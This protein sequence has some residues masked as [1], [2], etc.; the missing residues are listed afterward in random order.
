[1]LTLAT[2]VYRAGFS[3]ELG[4]LEYTGPLSGMV[5]EGVPVTDFAKPRLRAALRPLAS[6]LRQS[7]PRV[8]L[9]TFG[10]VNLALLALRPL[11]PADIRLVIREANTPSLSLAQ[12][13]APLLMGFAYR[14]LYPTA[15]L[16]LCQHGLMAAEM[17][18]RFGVSAERIAIL[19]N[20]V[21]V[22][23]LRQHP[24][25]RAPGSGRRFVAAGRLTRQKGFDRLVALFA[26]SD[27]RDQC[28]VFGDGPDRA[29]LERTIDDFGLTS[30]VRLVGFE[31]APWSWYAGADAVLV[32]SRWEGL[33]NVALEALACGTP[34]IATPE[35]GGIAEV[36]AAA[37]D[38]AVTVAPWGR[39]FA[40]AMAALTPARVEYPR[41]SL[42]PAR[43]E[44]ASVAAQF[45]TLLAAL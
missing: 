17:V 11:L 16:V 1:M 15:D 40:D 28:T 41:P 29:A 3:V 27:P 24:P 37:T 12:G 2:R 26:E 36:R 31:A 9:S 19:P 6:W 22:D 20:P 8:V 21:D 38:G 5:P 44:L 10:Y 32:P 42:L 13:R 7:R 14:L 45:E 23:A 35:S 25:R 30:R 39:D 18:D 4:V 43:Y 34:V 33:P